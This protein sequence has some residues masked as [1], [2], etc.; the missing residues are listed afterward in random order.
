MS[1]AEIKIHVDVEIHI[2]AIQFCKTTWAKS[3]WFSKKCKILTHVIVNAVRYKFKID[4]IIKV[5]FLLFL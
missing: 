1:I 5:F 4:L 2:F 3:F